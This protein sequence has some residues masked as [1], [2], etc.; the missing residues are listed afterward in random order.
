MQNQKKEYNIKFVC[1]PDSTELYIN[2][3]LQENAD[4]SDIPVQRARQF[5]DSFAPEQLLRKLTAQEKNAVLVFR[6]SSSQMQAF[7][8]MFQEKITESS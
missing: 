6:T 8:D 7:C 2:N 4:F 1:R 3:I 5:L